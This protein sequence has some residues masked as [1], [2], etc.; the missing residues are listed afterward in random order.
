MVPPQWVSSPV[1]FVDS[2]GLEPQTSRV[3]LFT[4]TTPW[5]KISVMHSTTKTRYVSIFPQFSG[6]YDRL[7]KALNWLVWIGDFPSKKYR[8]TFPFLRFAMWYP[9]GKRRCVRRALASSRPGMSSDSSMRTDSTGNT[10][11]TGMSSTNN[12]LQHCQIFLPKQGEW[13]NDQT[14][15]AGRLKG[16]GYFFATRPALKS[17]K[18]GFRLIRSYALSSRLLCHK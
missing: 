1:S 15:F 17:V 9:G 14:S 3:S 10:V 8:H 12:I 18:G 13:Q 4:V 16:R 11:L 5:K 2:S 7:E 6:L